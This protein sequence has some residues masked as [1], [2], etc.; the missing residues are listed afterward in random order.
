VYKSSNVG[1]I[2]IFRGV[3]ESSLNPK[4]IQQWCEGWVFLWLMVHIR[5]MTFE[6]VNGGWRLQQ[7][8]LKHSHSTKKCN[9]IAGK[10]MIG[11][12]LDIDG[13]PEI[14]PRC[15]LWAWKA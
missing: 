5:L 6:S 12:H 13:E 8:N 4:D 3:Q 14:R 1:I 2:R 7:R 15:D 9:S 10:S 11:R